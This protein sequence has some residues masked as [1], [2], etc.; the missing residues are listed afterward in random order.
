M[1][2]T[3]FTQPSDAITITTNK[4]AKFY[5]RQSG[6]ERRGSHESQRIGYHSQG[7][8]IM[9]GVVKKVWTANSFSNFSFKIPVSNILCNHLHGGNLISASFEVLYMDA[10]KHLV[11][12]LKL[13]KILALLLMPNNSSYSLKRTRD[14]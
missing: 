7:F 13:S 12:A 8:E 9:A 10:R 4:C 6:N 14:K 3:A 11:C 2:F 1:L 5:M